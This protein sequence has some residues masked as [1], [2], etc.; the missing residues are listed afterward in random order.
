MKPLSESPS[1]V[2]A[3]MTRFIAIAVTLGIVMA[4]ATLAS[5][6]YPLYEQ[7]LGITSAGITIAYSAYMAGALLALLSL[8]RLSEHVGFVH[9]LRVAILLLLVGLLISSDA[10]ALP[11]LAAGRFAIGLAAGMASSAATAGLAALEPHGQVRRAPLVGSVMTV[12]GFGL[13]PFAAGAAAQ[14]LPRPLLTPYLLF[15]VA[16]VLAWIALTVLPADGSIG[17]IR[18][19]RP[20]LRFHLPAMH[21]MRPFSL[22][23]LTTFIGYT[24]LSLYASLAPSFLVELLPWRGPAVTGAGV[25]LLFAGSA[26]AQLALRNVSPARGLTAGAALIA[27]S[28]GLLVLSLA[29]HSGVLFIASDLLGGFGQGLAF[30]SAV[31]VVNSIPS[32]EHGGRIVSSFFSVAYVGGIVPIVALGLMSARIGV[33]PSIAWLSAALVLLALLLA[34]IAHRTAKSFSGN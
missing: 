33:F 24:L 18:Q 20:K 19:F 16:A 11:V 10:H 34:T 22:A 32:G 15:A 30:M 26:L 4:S 28:I 9:A 13:G 1:G 27:A 3:A 2:Q 25:A 14:F 21:A 8:A 7:S 17:L 31:A 23:A 29:V 5:P 6:L 12:A